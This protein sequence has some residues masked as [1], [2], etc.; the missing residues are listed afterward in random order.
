MTKHWQ[1]LWPVVVLGTLSLS[2]G[3][4]WGRF[5]QPPTEAPG[6]IAIPASDG[7]VVDA[8]EIVPEEREV[9][10]ATVDTASDKAEGPA[11]PTVS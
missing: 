7:P 4:A 5:R 9:P 11:S 6:S 8:S 1:T 3:F 10:S 2:V